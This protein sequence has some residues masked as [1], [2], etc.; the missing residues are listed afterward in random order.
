FRRAL[1]NDL[2]G[3][4]PREPGD[5]VIAEHHVRL[6]PLELRFEPRPVADGAPF[7]GEPLILELAPLDPDIGVVVVDKEDPQVRRY[8]PAILGA[9]FVNGLP[10]STP[11]PQRLRRRSRATVP[12]R[13]LSLRGTV[14]CVTRIG[15]QVETKAAFSFR[16]R[17]AAPSSPSPL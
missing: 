16:K 10:R 2:E 11:L 17:A 5:R 3:L 1:A 8:R 13:Q 9:V 12:R 6:E 7:E 14:K 15:L 4:A